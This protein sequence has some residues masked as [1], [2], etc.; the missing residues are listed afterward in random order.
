[1]SNHPQATDW[2]QAALS[3]ASVDLA[4][5]PI[6]IVDVGAAGAPHP[7][8]A[9]IASISTYLG[10]DPDLRSPQTGNNFGFQKYSMINR[11]VTPREQASVM[12]HLTRFPECSSVLQPDLDQTRSYAIGD[13]FETLGQS[14]VPAITLDA[15]IEQAGLHHIDWLKLDTQGTDFD[16]LTSLSSARFDQLLIVEVEPGVAPFYHGEN[17]VAQIHAHMLQNG[18][19]LAHLSQQRFPR[20]SVDTIRSLGL[21]E[22]DISLLDSNPFALELRYCRSIEFL[23]SRNFT[24][25]DYLALWFVAMANHHTGY[26]IEVATAAR[27]HGLPTAACDALVQITLRSSRESLAN[28]PRAP[29]RRLAELCLPPLVMN[30]LRRVK[31]NFC[32]PRS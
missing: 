21:T 6:G 30:S 1:M 29:L 32:A 4:S 16:L 14:S 3:I 12:F 31:R 10:F 13:Y 28:H 24:A 8:L 23:K 27:Q 19:W 26:A 18:F 2:L 17:T 25:R 22:A 9:A 5:A 15:A 7:N 20:I 11:A